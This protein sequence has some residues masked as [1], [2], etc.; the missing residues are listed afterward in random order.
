[1]K[2][3]NRII[4]LL[5]AF[6]L[7]FSLTFTTPV[8]AADK[9]VSKVIVKNS[10]TDSTKVVYVAKGYKVKL[11]TDADSLGLFVGSGNTDVSVK[12]IVFKD[13]TLYRTLND[14]YDKQFLFYQRNC[15]LLINNHYL[16]YLHF[17]L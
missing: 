17:L 8:N 13:N 12:F 16:R 5:L 15:L 2:S 11:K 10:L 9:S 3:Y 7:F 6:I 14:D 1:M 4:A